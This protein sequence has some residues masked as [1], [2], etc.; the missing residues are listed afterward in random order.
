MPDKKHARL[1]LAD[2]PKAHGLSGAEKAKIRARAH[3]IL[4]HATPAM[5]LKSAPR[6]V[7][8]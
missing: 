6:K 4:G 2:L 1:A 8:K 3:K 5:K 7:K